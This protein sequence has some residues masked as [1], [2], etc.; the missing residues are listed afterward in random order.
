MLARFGLK[1]KMILAFGSLAVL[2]AAVG[3]AAATTARGVD[4]RRR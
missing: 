4:L 1:T 3:V 2:I